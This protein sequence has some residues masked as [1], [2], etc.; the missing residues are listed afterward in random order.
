M[1]ADSLHAERVKIIYATS[2]DVLAMFTKRT[3]PIYPYSA[4]RMGRTGSGIFRMYVN[5]QGIA[6]KIGVMKSTGHT[7]LDIAAA[8]GLIQWRAKLGRRREVDMPVTFTMRRR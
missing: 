2:A 3:A 7:E 5:E 6:T 1:F 4:R 8:A